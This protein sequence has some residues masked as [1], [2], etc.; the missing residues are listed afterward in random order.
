MTSKIFQ[1]TISKKVEDSQ[2]RT[3]NQKPLRNKEIFQTKLDDDHR[4]INQVVSRTVS[5]ENND[6]TAKSA[7]KCRKV[8]VKLI[9]F[10]MSPKI[11][12]CLITKVLITGIVAQRTI[13]KECPEEQLSWYYT[14]LKFEFEE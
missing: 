11:N 7:I 14:T 10:E 6:D 2:M 8:S 9:M 5:K 1:M 12:I 4:K 13:Y 3:N